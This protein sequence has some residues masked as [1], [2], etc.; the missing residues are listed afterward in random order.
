MKKMEPSKLQIFKNEKM[1]PYERFRDGQVRETVL[2][3]RHFW[4]YLK[5]QI[6][7]ADLNED[8]RA[9]LPGLDRVLHHVTLDLLDMSIIGR[10]EQ[11]Y[12]KR[13]DFNWYD[14]LINPPSWG[15]WLR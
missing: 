14:P 2:D 12:K 5:S 11:K 7:Q 10:L 1:L 15:I 13:V 3:N 9:R 6:I 4:V 8:P